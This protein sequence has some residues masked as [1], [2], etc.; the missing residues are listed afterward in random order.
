MNTEKFMSA[1][2]IDKSMS[3]SAPKVDR[4]ERYPFRE[5]DSVAVPFL[6]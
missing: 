6:S 2:H 1:S 5:N 3:A 4:K